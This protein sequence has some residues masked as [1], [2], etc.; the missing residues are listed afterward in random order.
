MS[1]KRI[2]IM[3]FPAHPAQVFHAAQHAIATHTRRPV[4]TEGITVHGSI[5]ASLWSWGENLSVMVE[6]DA[7]GAKVTASS[8]SALATQIIDYGRHRK[9]V[10]AIQAL[11]EQSLER[12]AR[13]ISPG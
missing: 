2:R 10:E 8:R 3:I 7:A 13:V 6:P 11:M 1:N 9:N 5:E 12:S 4:H